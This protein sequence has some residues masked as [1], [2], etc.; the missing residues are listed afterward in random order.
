MSTPSSPM[1]HTASSLSTPDQS[2]RRLSSW[3]DLRAKLAAVVPEAMVIVK[4]LQQG[5]VEEAPIEIRI[6]GDDIA[7]L[8]QIGTQVEAIVRA[9]PFSR[10]VHRDYFNDSYMV[11][12]DLNNELANRL[13]MT[14]A[15]GLSDP[16]R[17]ALTASRSAPSGRA[18]GRLP[19]CFA[20]TRTRALPSTMCGYLHDPSSPM[21][22]CRSGPLP[23]SSRNGRP[24]AS[25]AG[26]A[27]GPLPSALSSRRGFTARPV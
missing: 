22:G 1:A 13:G 3:H 25:C 2:K 23:L 19:S 10:Y 12:V 15:C 27:S 24:A 20:S 5:S 11:D 14:N 21:P 17:R 16:I 6:S 26:T 9:V 8:K 7:T 18:T 4:E